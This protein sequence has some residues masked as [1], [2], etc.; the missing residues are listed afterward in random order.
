MT[1]ARKI[2]VEE[3]RKR[4]VYILRQVVRTLTTFEE[5]ERACKEANNALVYG[6]EHTEK[7]TLL[8]MSNL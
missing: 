4:A 6:L 8:D 5:I 2:S 1:P 7:P 3:R